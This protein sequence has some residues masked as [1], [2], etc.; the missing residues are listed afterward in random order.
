MDAYIKEVVAYLQDS[1]RLSQ[2]ISFHLSVDSIEL[3]ITPGRTLRADHHEAL[4]N[5]FSTPSPATGLAR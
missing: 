5:A 3:V 2:P 1:Y 4:T